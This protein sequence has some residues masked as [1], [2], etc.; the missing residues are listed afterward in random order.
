MSGESGC[1]YVCICMCVCVCVSAC[2]CVCL[3]VS[4]HM[5]KSCQTDIF[6]CMCEGVQVPVPAS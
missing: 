1:V 2:M 4:P 3:G 5:T 6:L